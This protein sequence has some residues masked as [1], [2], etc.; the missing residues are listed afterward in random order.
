LQIIGTVNFARYLEEKPNLTKYLDDKLSETDYAIQKDIHEPQTIPGHVFKLID[1][2]KL[3]EEGYLLKQILDFTD[4]EET[5][6]D[7]L[8]IS[9]NYLD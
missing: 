1:C 7:E 6:L 8:K 9:R 4:F 3:E 5:I 2:N